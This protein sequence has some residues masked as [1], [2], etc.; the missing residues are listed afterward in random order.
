M[1]NTTLPLQFGALTNHKFPATR[2][3]GSKLKISNWIWDNV[4]DIKFT[5]VLDAFGG[6][7]CMSYLFKTQGKV[8]T[9]NDILK[10]NSFIGKALVENNSITL[11]EV[12]VD[13]LLQRS[14]DI[15]YPTLIADH[16][17]NIYYTKDENIWLDTVVCN[18]HAMDDIYKKAIAFFAL[19]QSCII[20][21]PFNLFHRKNLYIRMSN[22]KRN[23]GNK[24]TWDA[25][26]E[27]YF[28]KFVQQANDAV[29][30]NGQNNV[31]LNEDVFNIKNQ[32]DL[33]YID[34]PYISNT[35]STVD[36][37]HFYHFLE[38]LANYP[39]WLQNID[40]NCKHKRL[41][42][43]KN[44]WNDKILI[45]EAFDQL[46]KHFQNSVL[47]V[48]YRSDG[49]PSIAELEQLISKYKSRIVDYKKIG[50]KYVLSNNKCHETLIIGR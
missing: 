34:T 25:P 4:K 28:R 50:Y 48:S 38:G 14:R 16:F 40:F 49:V 45:H 13:S 6:T 7:G 35:G 10:F 33:V 43:S 8:V 11:T 9:Y 3:Q 18:I 23:F 17:D 42:P 47:V 24:T 31:A 5:S 37:H 41:Q 21:R 30:Y 36:Y 27:T 20:K 2:F 26:F 44:V 39:D 12:D 22:V 29:F 1:T 15:D 32:Y 46:F 19:F